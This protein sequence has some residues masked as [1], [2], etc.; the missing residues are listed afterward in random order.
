M[1]HMR[2][3][4][5]AFLGERGAFSGVQLKSGDVIAADI[6]IIGAGACS[7]STTRTCAAAKAL[8]TRV[9]SEAGALWTRVCPGIIPATEF[10]RG[11]PGVKFH[12]DGSIIVDERFEVTQ[13]PL[14]GP[15]P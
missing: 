10:L 13:L 7:H 4:V 3:V 6:C 9:V 8:L 11:Q 12:T 14:P 15:V 5:E 2:A 1:F